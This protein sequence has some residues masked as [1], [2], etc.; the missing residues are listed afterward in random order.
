MTVVRD[1]ANLAPV[2][3]RRP[4]DLLQAILGFAMSVALGVVLALSAT[5]MWQWST[6]A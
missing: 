1:D 3:Y 4:F 5:A 6:E 2:R